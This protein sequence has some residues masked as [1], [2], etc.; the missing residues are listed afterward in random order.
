MQIMNLREIREEYLRS[1]TIQQL[2]LLRAM[3]ETLEGPDRLLCM[4]L[5]SFGEGRPDFLDNE[6]A[7]LAVRRNSRLLMSKMTDL[8][9]P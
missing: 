3:L 6:S 9:K 7:D 5:I 4:R 1:G 2:P 8:S